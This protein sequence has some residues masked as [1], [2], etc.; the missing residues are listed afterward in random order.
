MERTQADFPVAC[1]LSGGIDSGS[2]ACSITPKKINTFIIFLLLQKDENYDESKMIKKILDKKKIKHSYVKAKKKNNIS[3]L[4]IIK[5]II[6]K[7][8]NLV[9]TVSWLL[10]SYICKEIKRKRFKVVLTGTG[11]DE[12][13]LQV[14]MLIIYIFYNH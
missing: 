6:D 13:F 4:K 14:T 2:I 12:I 10:F 11:G 7:T 1:L 3:N 5:N 9:P 8:G